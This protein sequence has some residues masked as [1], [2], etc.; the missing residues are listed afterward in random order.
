[1]KLYSDGL[2]VIGDDSVG[3]YRWGL[4]RGLSRGNRWVDGRMPHWDI[5]GLSEAILGEGVER[6]STDDIAAAWREIIGVR[7]EGIDEGDWRL[8]DEEVLR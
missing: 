6:V 3:L 8:G 5:S 4:G 7:S 2:V 1:M